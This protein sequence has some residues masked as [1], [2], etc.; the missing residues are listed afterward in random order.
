VETGLTDGEI[1]LPRFE[2]HGDGVPSAE[3]PGFNLYHFHNVK[4]PD[5][6]GVTPS[7]NWK[8]EW[9]LDEQNAEVRRVLIQQIGFERISS[10]LGAVEIDAWRE[11]RLLNIDKYAGG[12]PFRILKMVC[13]STGHVHTGRVP[14]T[15]AKARA[16]ATW[17]NFGVD[18]EKFA[19]EC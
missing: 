8:S 10:E 11:Y 7:P 9:L 14:P 4:I 6:M 17:R 3:Y 18:P 13:P 16:A 1:R 12:E 5:R 15:I 19:V 2:L